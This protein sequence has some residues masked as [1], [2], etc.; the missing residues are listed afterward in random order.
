[1]KHGFPFDPTYGYNLDSLKQVGHPEEPADFVSFWTNRFNLTTQI[2]PRIERRIANGFKHPDIDVFEI[3]FDSLDQFRVGGWLTV[4]KTQRVSRGI[5]IGHGYGGRTQPDLF[6]SDPPAA[7]IFPCAR[8]FDRSM[9]PNLPGQ[10]AAHVLHGIETP[11]TYL[12]GK[13]AADLWAASS[14]L[15]ELFPQTAEDLLY[16]GVSFGGGIGALA[17]AWDNRLRRAFLD[18]PTFGNHPLRLTMQCIGSG[19]SVRQYSKSHPHVIN[20]LQYFDAATA[21]HHTH[22]PV[23]VS[24]AV[25]DPA[26]PPPGQFAVY[27]SLAGARRLFVREASHF[28]FPGQTQ[29]DARLQIEIKDWFC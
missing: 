10:A 9:R 13:C 2:P 26:V 3:E 15:L 25:F 14:A 8:G 21:A 27:N 17:I 12:P 4:P 22:I 16:R 5:V 11:Q 23:M 19:E 6:L 7:M 20:V 29:E 1:M 28:T 24:A 18:V